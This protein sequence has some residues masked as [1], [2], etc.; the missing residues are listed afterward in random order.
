MLQEPLSSLYFTSA[1]HF[2]QLK[3][4]EQEFSF[5]LHSHCIRSISCTVV[6]VFCTNVLLRHQYVVI[7]L[8]ALVAPYSSFCPF[9]IHVIGQNARAHLV[10]R[11]IR[12]CQKGC[13]QKHCKLKY[14]LCCL[15]T[16]VEA[17]CQDD[18][19]VQRGKL[20]VPFG[21]CLTWTTGNCRTHVILQ[22]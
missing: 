2:T 14:R 3:T 12:R 11:S 6:I 1:L 10:F 19:S 7:S 4:E 17:I 20:Q 9:R 8:I 13:F 18:F 22:P 21:S 15:L 16:F 5:L